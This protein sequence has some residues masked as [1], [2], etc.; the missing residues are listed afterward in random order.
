MTKEV[1]KNTVRKE[2][3][4]RVLFVDNYGYQPKQDMLIKAPN[5]PTAE[6]LA[7]DA[8]WDRLM[9]DVR[10]LTCGAIPVNNDVLLIAP[11]YYRTLLDGCWTM[12]EC[13]RQDNIS[14]HVSKRSEEDVA[15]AAE[16]NRR[17]NRKKRRWTRAEKQARKEA[18][19]HKDTTVPAPVLVLP[20]KVA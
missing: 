13:E 18:K 1:K 19:L 9:S 16:K 20:T 15:A 11:Q 7:H 8:L 4:Y 2:H 3:L 6:K 17:A 12:V 10:M 5:K 14:S